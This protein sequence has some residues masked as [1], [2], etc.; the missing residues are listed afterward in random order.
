MTFKAPS[1]HWH[2]VTTQQLLII[3]IT[4][5]WLNTHKPCSTSPHSAPQTTGNKYKKEKK[6]IL[7]QNKGIFNG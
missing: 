7:N 4:T 5:M 1:S 6:K 3:V 2:S